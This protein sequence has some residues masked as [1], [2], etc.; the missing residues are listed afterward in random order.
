MNAE[1]IKNWLMTLVGG[2][3]AALVAWNVLTPDASQD[4][5]LLGTDIVDALD[6]LLLA[7]WALVSYGGKIMPQRA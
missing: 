2:V 7:I 5:T 6:S 3:L 1:S 4:L